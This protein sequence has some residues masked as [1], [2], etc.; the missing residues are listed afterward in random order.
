MST[1][2]RHCQNRVQRLRGFGGDTLWSSGSRGLAP[3]VLRLL[4]CP[5][6]SNPRRGYVSPVNWDWQVLPVRLCESEP[7]MISRMKSAGALNHSEIPE[8]IAAFQSW[9]SSRLFGPASRLGART[10]TFPSLYSQPP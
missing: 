7:W 4:L 1:M 3:G 9:V 2:S 5:I 8:K 6:C 10:G